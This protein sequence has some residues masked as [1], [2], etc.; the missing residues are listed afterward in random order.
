MNH[1]TRIAA[2]GVACAGLG[3]C[4]GGGS[5]AGDDATAAVTA[6]RA[7]AGDAAT[8]EYVAAAA[9]GTAASSLRV[10]FLLP[11]RPLP[12]QP[13]SVVLAVTTGEGLSDLAFEASSDT[14]AVDPATASGK[15]GAL[16]AGEAGEFTVAFT[17]DAAGLGDIA[18]QLRAVT[19]N[20]EVLSRF[21]VPVLVG[22]SP[23][24]AG[25]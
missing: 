8:P 15:L 17:A 9:L 18:L 12:G 19:E 2:L 10:A 13:A 4:S 24:Q 16:G 11:E 14:F 6:G 5:Q 7:S 23:A 25:D 22:Q 1:W 21:A 20:G 3:A